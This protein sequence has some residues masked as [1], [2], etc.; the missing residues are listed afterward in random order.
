MTISS[1]VS[2]FALPKCPQLVRLSDDRPIPRPLRRS[3]P[4]FLS[5]HF[6]F[7]VLALAMLCMTS[8]SANSLLF[9]FT[10]I[11]MDGDANFTANQN[12]LLIAG[13][14]IGGILA[15][16]PV[17]HAI[18]L[19]GLRYVFALFGLLSGLVTLLMPVL[20]FSGGG[21]YAIF[22]TRIVQGLTLMPAMP[23]MS[24]ITHN[25]ANSANRENALFLMVL[26]LYMQFSVIMT[27]PTT[28]ALCESAWRWPSAFFLFGFISLFLFLLFL[29][30]YRN[31]P[32]Q[33]P[34]VSP[35]ELSA[36][37]QF[38]RPAPSAADGTRIRR[39]QRV[40]IVQMCRDSSFWACCSAGLSFGIAYWLFAQ[41]GPTYMNKVLNY[42][43]DSAGIFVAVP[44]FFAIFA[45]ML[46]PLADR[47]PRLS[48]RV[49]IV[50]I[51]CVCQLVNIVCYVLLAL[52][53]SASAILAQICFAVILCANGAGFVA[54][55]N[56]CQMIAQQHAH[57][58]LALFALINYIITLVQPLVIS[59][60]ASE[61]TAEE[62][63]HLFLTY[64]F[65]LCVLNLAFAFGAST[66][67]R[68]WT[69]EE[70]CRRERN[71]AD[72]GKERTKEEKF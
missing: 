8:I 21:F 31:S 28:G 53:P 70:N 69:K 55:A 5:D 46:V 13:T 56:N 62:W 39:P 51:P 14:A 49:R 6:R 11:C 68:P 20:F 71:A 60:M 9:N 43:A 61:N 10:V 15:I 36:L 42:K 32:S 50:W 19:F 47:V 16:G 17:P 35:R 54:V 33:S 52:W 26:S 59:W 64:A 24:Q 29:F 40:P 12:G 72:G 57:F 65:I 25:W 66:E 18:A 4:F 67:P 30:V 1:N 38:R 3:L 44:Y 41:F 23:A 2:Q 37:S 58:L 7:V 45:K 48:L 27:M 63:S 34:F 22:A